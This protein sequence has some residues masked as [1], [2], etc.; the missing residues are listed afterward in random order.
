MFDTHI[1]MR[2]ELF[3]CHFCQK[4]DFKSPISVNLRR[5]QKVCVHNPNRKTWRC[6]GCD[7]VFPHYSGLA[8]HR[9][10]RAHGDA[11]TE[12]RAR[13][14][15]A[16][17]TRRSIGT[18]QTQSTQ[19]THTQSTQSTQ[20]TSDRPR[21]FDASLHPD[22]TGVPRSRFSILLVDPPFRY[23]KARGR[24]VAE[25]HYRTTSDEYLASLPVGSLA[26]RDALLFVWCSGATLDH[27]IALCSAWGFAYK[28][29]AFVWV[30]TNRSGDPQSIALG[31]Y[32]R[33]GSEFVLLATRGRGSRLV[34]DRV[35]QV[36]HARRL[37][38]SAK[39]AR[40]AETIDRLARGDLKKIELFARGKP[41]DGWS[42][43]GDEI[44]RDGR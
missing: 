30:K 12:T 22:L 23:A 27:A 42:A 5:H 40:V 9:K 44:E 41:R 28:T 3:A 21:C 17:E 29:V 16:N 7:R 20:S 14:R 26:T 1:T 37:A 11:T 36:F 33:P 32:T 25:N 6:D 24:G 18:S 38:H 10:S 4:N 19:S 31:S 43:W 13:A 8:K 15:D 34:S 39:P 35:D 2:A